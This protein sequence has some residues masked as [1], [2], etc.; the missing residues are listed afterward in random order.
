MRIPYVIDDQQHW[1][2]E[3]LNEVLADYAR[4]FWT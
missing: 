2:T 4:D 1:L 3:A